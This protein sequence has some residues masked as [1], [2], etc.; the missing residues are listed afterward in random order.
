[1]EL[2][3]AKIWHFLAIRSSYISSLMP[4]S[5]ERGYKVIIP[6]DCNSTSDNDYMD[7]ESTYKYYNEMMWPGRFAKC[8][9]TN[10]V[11]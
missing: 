7:A 9:D 2:L 8:I 5:M 3:T 11:F 4:D 1:M 10:E 6:K